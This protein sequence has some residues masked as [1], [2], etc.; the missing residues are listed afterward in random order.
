MAK[1]KTKKASSLDDNPDCIFIVVGLI[2]FVVTFEK[3]NI[4][5]SIALSQEPARSRRYKWS[6]FVKRNI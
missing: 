5:K 3:I 2:I 6:T 1:S 4:G